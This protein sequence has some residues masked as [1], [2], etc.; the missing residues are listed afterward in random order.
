MNLEERVHR[1]ER[2]LWAWRT[3]AVCLLLGLALLGF[4]LGGATHQQAVAQPA[5]G[6]ITPGAIITDSITV[7]NPKADRIEI[8]F[9]AIDMF[10][11]EAVRHLTDAQ[12]KVAMKEYVLNYV[13]V[14]PPP[15]WA[16]ANDTISVEKGNHVAIPVG[17]FGKKVLTA[18]V[19]LIQNSQRIHIDNLA[20]E[21]KGS[22]GYGKDLKAG[23]V[24]IRTLF[25]DP[26]AGV[27]IRL[28]VIYEE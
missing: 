14:L 1:I 13:A 27:I 10:T 20:A 15:R 25:N 21:Y 18:W 4:C 2:H 9:N 7:G 6:T 12:C 28:F 24:T 23:E 11:K 3:V 5:K 16:K 8:K 19:M 17:T 26:P 22:S